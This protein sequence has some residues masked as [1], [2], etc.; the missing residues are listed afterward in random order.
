MLKRLHNLSLFGKLVL[1]VAAAVVGLLVLTA[2][3]LAEQRRG[4]MAERTAAVQQ[5]VDSVFGIIARYHEL[6]ARGVLTEAEAKKAALDAIRPLRY[7]NNEYFW[8]NDM[9]SVSVMHPIS[10]ELEGKDLSGRKDPTGK[11]FFVEFAD[12]VSKS[13]SGFV[14]YMWP[15]PGS[16]QPVQKV[17]FV[18]GFAPWGWIIGSG[19]YMDNVEQ[20]FQRRLVHAAL[21]T[22]AVAAVLLALG[23][24]LARSV[25]RQLGGEPAH[26]VAVVAQVASGDL[27][28]DVRTRAGD[29][30]SLLAAMRQ[31]THSLAAV[32]GGVR[33]GTDT[34]ATA[35]GQI[36]A[37]NQDLSAR[38]EEQ[39]ASLEQTAASMEEL[40]GTVKQNADNARHADALARSTSEVAER[41]GAVVAEV[42]ATM[43]GINDASKKIADIIGVI[44]GIAFQTNILAL[45]AA[46]EAA[47]AG[48]QGRGFAVVASEVRNLAQRSATA[49]KEIK[50]LIADSVG[51]VDAGSALVARAGQTMEEVVAGIRQVTGIMAD[52]AAASQEQTAGIEQ[53]NRAMT[54]M[55]QVTQQNAA[56]VEEAAA[57]AQALREQADALVQAV[58]AF[59][60]PADAEA[61]RLIRRARGGTQAAAA[62]AALLTADED[63]AS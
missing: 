57:A 28:A 2:L 18:R 1:L 56:L 60:L 15:K 5:T 9:R 52:I 7:G 59:T 12:T 36:A 58:A 35:A 25:L 4:L 48:E 41:G 16:D 29:D 24:L 50:T 22:A 39:A 51:R 19:V 17:T 13:G 63:T 30:A 43:A 46:V 54:Q 38:T 33:D 23:L 37:G 42:V 44:D 40:T 55:D 62:P 27:T 61:S 34:I 21:G 47:R 11:A 45:N 53:V 49:A 14:Y 6:A 3:S 26:A 10:P 20:E 32:I 8:V 31:M